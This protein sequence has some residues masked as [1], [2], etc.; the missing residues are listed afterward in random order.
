MNLWTVLL[1]RN[2]FVHF[3]LLL[4]SEGPFTS[5]FR[6]GSLNR[7]RNHIQ[8]LLNMEN[9][10]INVTNMR[11]DL[12]PA[13]HHA[14]NREVLDR[15]PAPP[16]SPQ[17]FCWLDY[18]GALLIKRCYILMI[19]KSICECV[20]HKNLV[21]ISVKVYF[22]SSIKQQYTVFRSRNC[23]IFTNFPSCVPIVY[24]II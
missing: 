4:C 21:Q 11:N 8:I 24:A 16:H 6:A 9:Y 12:H 10:I 23:K 5:H 22:F 15:V 19:C 3:Q 1:W 20:W 17:K 18:L 2:Y 14:P 7:M 13:L